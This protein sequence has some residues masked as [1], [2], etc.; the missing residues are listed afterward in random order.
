M[1]R[2]VLAEAEKPKEAGDE[3]LMGKSYEAPEEKAAGIQI[4]EVATEEQTGSLFTD[5]TPKSMNEQ[6]SRLNNDPML[7]VCI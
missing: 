1:Y 6:W 4:M 7:M 5:D 2:G 3:F